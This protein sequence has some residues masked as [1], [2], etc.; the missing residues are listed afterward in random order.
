M[1]C[2]EVDFYSGRVIDHFVVQHT[3]RL[4]WVCKALSFSR[5][6]AVIGDAFSRLGG[7]GVA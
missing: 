6:A 3:I 1:E 2:F 7:D 4:H 5:A